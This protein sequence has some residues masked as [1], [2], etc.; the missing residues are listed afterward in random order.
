MDIGGVRQ[1][2][3]AMGDSEEEQRF[4]QF[5]S[6]VAA[7]VL[8]DKSAKSLEDARA[9]NESLRAQLGDLQY[10]INFNTKA[11]TQQLSELERNLHA[12]KVCIRAIHSQPAHLVAVSNADAIIRAVVLAIMRM[13]ATI[14]RQIESSV[15]S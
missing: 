14:L 7:R 12:L 5:N 15:P 8:F 13:T 3:G 4:P 11:H 1:E 6:S 9:E 10:S 2:T